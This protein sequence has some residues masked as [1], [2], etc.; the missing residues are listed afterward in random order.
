M[1]F[2]ADWVWEKYQEQFGKQE[3]T[4]ETIRIRHFSHR[5]NRVAM[6][7]Y[8][9]DYRHDEY[10]PSQH[11]TISTER[12][13]HTELFRY[14]DDS[15]LPGLPDASNPETALALLNQHVLAFRARQ[16]IRVQL[17]RYRPP[18]RAIFRHRVG[19]IRLYARVVRP[20]S[21]SRILDAQRLISTSNFVV[22]RVTGAWLDGGVIWFSEIPG[23]NLRRRILRGK[24]PDTASLITRLESLW[25]ELSETSDG[26][27]FN[28]AG[29]YYTARRTF[30]H[31]IDDAPMAERQFKDATKV[32]DQFVRSWRPTH[33]AH[34]DFYDD[35]MLQLPDGRVALVDFE[36]TGPGDPMLDVGNCLAH[37]KW[38]SQFSR[39]RSK[40]ASGEFH[41]AFKS[42][43]LNQFRWH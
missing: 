26:R 9:L 8:L 20:S 24:L 36:E 33:I 16:Q 35:Q 37:L 23:A 31:V 12:D 15:R 29:A 28:L 41:A 21:V 14:P 38:L 34:N 40:N 22:P 42:H 30:T 11:L 18:S 43:S 32:L 3:H 25:S 2:D 7:S 10:L 4:L 6:A 1:L 27:P 17:V 5:P 13:A 19:R 39:R